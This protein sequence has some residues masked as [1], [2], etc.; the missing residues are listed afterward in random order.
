[1]VTFFIRRTNV[2]ESDSGYSVEV[3]GRTWLRYVEGGRIL[4]IGCEV[5]VGPRGLAVYSKQIEVESSRAAPEESISS[6]ERSRIMENISAA[7]KFRSFDID[8][9]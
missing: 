1:M 7:F 9:T 2:I 8:I 6:E 5:L 4:R 3:L